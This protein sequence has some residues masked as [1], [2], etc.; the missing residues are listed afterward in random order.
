MLGKDSNKLTE[1]GITLLE[2]MIS[3]AIVG[4]GFIAV[5]QMVNYSVRS[6]GVSGE[7]TKATYLVSMIAEDL[8]SE[9]HSDSPTTDKKLM[10]YLIDNRSSTK[11]PSW[12]M[13]SCSQGIT[14]T[15]NKTNT[16]DNKK[17]KWDNRFSKRRI[18]CKGG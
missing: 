12:S 9:K 18:K 16:F 6:I 11:G 8:I 14:S 5:F 4:I 17:D 10:D 2:A 13:A 7:R 15:G 1:K 3:T